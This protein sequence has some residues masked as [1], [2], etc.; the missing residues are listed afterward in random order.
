MRPTLLGFRSPKERTPDPVLPLVTYDGR[1]LNFFP[2]LNSISFSKEKRFKNYD[3]QAKNANTRVGPGSYSPN[4]EKKIT[5]GY[6]YRNIIGKKFLDDK[7]YFY[8]DNNLVFDSRMGKKSKIFLS[9]KCEIG[10]PISGDSFIRRNRS[11]YRSI[12]NDGS[13]KSL[14][15]VNNDRGKCKIKKDSRA[16]SKTRE[17][18][19]RSVKIFSKLLDERFK[20]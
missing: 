11:S 20:Y 15:L 5:G 1:K 3:V 19:T 7:G 2:R 17:K 8:V 6:L 4:G 13:K 9:D 10:S 12:L 18:K 14:V 16:G